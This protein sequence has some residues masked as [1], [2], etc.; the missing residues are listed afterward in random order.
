MSN[1][2]SLALAQDVSLFG[3]ERKAVHVE[4]DLPPHYS[5]LEAR[6]EH[7]PL[8]SVFWESRFRRGRLPQRHRRSR[9]SWPPSQAI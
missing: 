2:N 1:R 8:R 5:P 3:G 9:R 4:E 6:F 7:G